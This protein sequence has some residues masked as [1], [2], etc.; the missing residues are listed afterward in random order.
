MIDGMEMRHLQTFVIA[1][2][3]QSFTRAA[4]VL[5]LTQAAVSQHIAALEKE[6]RTALFDRGP[7][8]VTLTDTGR[9]VY[10]HT[11]KI[12]DLVDVIHQESGQ[13]SSAVS[14]TIKIA[15]STVPSE[16]LLPEL[17]VRFR[18]LC[19]DVQESVSVSD[20]A[21]AIHSVESGAAEVGL[22]GELPRAA[23]LCAKSIAQDELTLVVAPDHQF[24]RTKRIKPD[25]LRGQPLI[26][27]EPGS[28][29]RR[30]VE[31]A[32]SNAGL[33]TTDLRFSMEVN[34]NDAIRAA[35]QRGVGISF[36][37]TRAIEREIHDKRLIPVEIEGVRAIRDLYL[38]TDPQRLPTRVDRAFLEFLD[39]WRRNAGQLARADQ[40]KLH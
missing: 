38:V 4:E 13:Q 28:G 3:S 24:A 39:D 37:S 19:P 7:R 2:E 1:A 25:D 40:G 21:A 10:E 35:V 20:S 15:C 30:C 36:L 32:L 8:S 5:G 31:Q 27:R 22:V 29:S 14:G 34:S 33:A 26:V 17:L 11:R 23:N 16:W 12:L 6:L 9:R 18:E